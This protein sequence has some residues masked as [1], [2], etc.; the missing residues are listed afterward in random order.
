MVLCTTI[1]NGA[2]FLKVSPFLRCPN[3]I[4]YFVDS[5]NSPIPWKT[6]RLQPSL[7][8]QWKDGQTAPVIVFLPFLPPLGHCLS[9]SRQEYQLLMY[10]EEGEEREGQFSHA[11]HSQKSQRK[12]KK[13]CG[14]C[15]CS[16]KLAEILYFSEDGCMGINR[17]GRNMLAFRTVLMYLGR[18]PTL[19]YRNF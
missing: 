8:T 6:L 12:K 16:C 15:Q 10:N 7:F 14:L 1:H 3:S 4:F 19:L 13:T 9:S 5:L 17:V 11:S 18:E 2:V